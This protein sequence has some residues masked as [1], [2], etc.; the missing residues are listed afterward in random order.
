MSLN[1][2]EPPETLTHVFATVTAAATWLKASH[3]Q[4]IGR[5]GSECQ[6]TGE[7]DPFPT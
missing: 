5:G 3:P 7:V 6:P 4:Y 1:L 2:L